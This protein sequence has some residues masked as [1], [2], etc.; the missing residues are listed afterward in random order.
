MVNTA[1][2]APSITVSILNA[3]QNQVNRESRL[4]ILPLDSGILCQQNQDWRR[5]KMVKGDDSQRAAKAMPSLGNDARAIELVTAMLAGHLLDIKPEL[6]FTSEMGYTYPFMEE[7]LKSTGQEAVSVLESLA[8]EGILNKDFFDRFLQCPQCRSVNLRPTTHCP[9]CASGNIARGRVLEHSICG[10]VGLEDEFTTQG[11]LICPKC[12]AEL[13]KLEGDYRS[14]GL[15]RKCYACGDVFPIP[16]IKWRCLKCSSITSEDK[17]VEVNIYSYSLD[18][19]KRRWLEFEL[20]PKAQ[21]TEFL[22][23]RGYEVTVNAT[24]EGRSGAKHSFDILATR[25]TSIITHD[26]A[27]GI[28]VAGDTVSLRDVFEFD[29]KAYDTGIHEKVLL[30]DPPLDEEAAAFASHQMIKVLPL[31]ELETVLA[32]DAPPPAVAVDKGPFE[33]KSISQLVEHLKRHAYEV[34]QKTAVKGRSG[35]EHELYALATRDEGIV[36][37]RIAI[38]MKAGSKPVELGKVFDFDAKAY[39]I[40]I[41]DKVFIVGS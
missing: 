5:W 27:I 23:Q 22:K 16:V 12:K 33:F 25:D 28:K 7:T 30:V 34:E 32:I 21:L 6:D 15:M 39:D 19:A 10:Y 40:G 29:D 17:V 24:R 3:F 36:T 31:E 9:R 41:Q 11:R 18:E 26:I 35:A 37:H 8:S 1:I 4:L 13:R 20:K 14:L 38:G 2:K